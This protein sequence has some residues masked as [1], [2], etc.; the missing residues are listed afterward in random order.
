M[1]LPTCHI[2][3]GERLAPFGFVHQ[4]ESESSWRNLTDRATLELPRN[5]RLRQASL[6]DYVGN[7]DRLAVRLGYDGQ[8]AAVYEGFVTRVVPDIPYRVYADDGMY[9]LKRQS[10]TASWRDISLAGLITALLPDNYQALG[11]RVE[12]VESGL[13]RFSVHKATLGQV[14]EVLREEYALPC[15]FRGKTLYAGLS[16]WP[17]LQARH[18]FR[19]QHNVV[20]H[21]L[22]WR[23]PGDTP[24]RVLAISMLPDNRKLHV[25]VGDPEGEVRT[26][27]FY[28]RSLADL[29]REAEAYLDRL[30]ISGY[31]GSF[32]TFGTPQVQHG[33]LVTLRDDYFPERNEG[34]YLVDAVRTTYGIGGYR[35]EITLGPRASA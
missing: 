5:V 13:G 18:S 9:L 28:D 19:F 33:D 4:Y 14:L 31:R 35:Q 23:E 2:T 10:T 26:L 6:R 16:Y 32:V 3:L 21:D 11:Y 1:F 17:K 25:E 20:S 7:G 12:A 15:F 27:H 34:A 30:R 22:E 24:L 29:R 8:T